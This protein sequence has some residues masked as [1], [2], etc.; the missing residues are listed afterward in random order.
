MNANTK[1]T[2]ACEVGSGNV[3]ERGH[4][5][6]QAAR[7]QFG[8]LMEQMMRSRGEGGGYKITIQGAVDLN[9]TAPREMETEQLMKKQLMKVREK[10]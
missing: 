7:R 2:K 6:V 4:S 9:V 10:R 1:L 8:T 5:R 3:V